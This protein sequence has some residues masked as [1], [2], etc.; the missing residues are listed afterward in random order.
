MV[1][2]RGAR[3][4]ATVKTEGNGHGGPIL[5]VRGLKTQFYTQDG[6]VKAVDDVSF[7][8]MPGRHSASSASPAVAR[9]P[10]G[11]S[12]PVRSCSTATTSCA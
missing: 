10:P 2:K 1:A 11:K 5:D 9:A 4:R 3:R 12:W 6:V 7:H 8:V